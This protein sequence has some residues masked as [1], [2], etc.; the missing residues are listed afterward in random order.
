MHLHNQQGPMNLPNL[1]AIAAC[2]DAMAQQME[3]SADTLCGSALFGKAGSTLGTTVT[4]MRERASQIRQMTVAF[5]QS[6]DV[7]E[8]NLACSLAGWRPNQHSLESFSVM[9]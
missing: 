1:T 8:F 6:G 9:H 3:I 2:M 5:R 4:S 7:A